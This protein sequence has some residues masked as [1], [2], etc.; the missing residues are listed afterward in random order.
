MKKLE[1]IYLH[2]A[3][4]QS[5][6]CSRRKAEKLVRE[7]RIKVNKETILSPEYK[8]NSAKDTISINGFKIRAEEEKVY[9]LLNKPEDVLSAVSDE[10]GEKTVIDLLPGSLGIRIYPVGRLDKDTTGLLIL[11][12]DG[13]LAFRLTHPKFKIIKTYS[14]FCEGRIEKRDLLK[15]ERGLEIDGKKTLPAKIKNLRFDRPKNRTSLLIEIYEGRKRQVKRMFLEIGRPVLN[16]KRIKYA[17][18]SLGKLKK[19]EFRPLGKREIAYLKEKTGL[20][21]EKGN[22]C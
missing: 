9:F 20:L 15:L 6:Y 19:G 21:N 11:T 2:L 8:I 3:I 16:L 5:G 7:G 13:Q 18:L 14:V 22:D 17:G 4:A 12:N 10:R 1:K